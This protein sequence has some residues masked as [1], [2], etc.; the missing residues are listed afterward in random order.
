MNR[1]SGY[2]LEVAHHKHTG[3]FELV[4]RHVLHQTRDDLS[5]A[6]Q[7]ATTL[8]SPTTSHAD[9]WGGGQETYGARLLLADVDVLNVE[10]VCFRVFP[11]FHDLTGA[12]VQARAA[13]HIPHHITSHHHTY[14]GNGER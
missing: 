11:G 3:A 7:T 13:H 9:E 1:D 4:Q 12:N 5:A 8:S 14:P 2:T 10:F 6:Q